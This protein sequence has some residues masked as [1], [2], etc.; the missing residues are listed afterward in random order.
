MA[1]RKAKGTGFI[2]VDEIEF[3]NVEFECS[4]QPSKATPTTTTVPPTT[5]KAPTTTPA[6]TTIPTTTVEPTEPIDCIY[7]SCA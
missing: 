4:F 3:R 6:L 5:T 7:Y 1:T 2:T